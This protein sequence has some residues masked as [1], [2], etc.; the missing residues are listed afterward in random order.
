MEIYAKLRFIIK[1]VILKKK[2]L[3]VYFLSITKLPTDYLFYPFEW[4]TLHQKLYHTFLFTKC[5]PKD[6]Q[7]RFNMQNRRY[8]EIPLL[9]STASPPRKPFFKIIFKSGNIRAYKCLH[10]IIHSMRVAIWHFNILIYLQF[11]RE[12][13]IHFSGI[14]FLYYWKKKI[15]LHDLNY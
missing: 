12:M 10:C 11:S 4:Y 1:N 3:S 5:C 14:T 6:M 8:L 13:K 9:K 7:T 15:I 2:D